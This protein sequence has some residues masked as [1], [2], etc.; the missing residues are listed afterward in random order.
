MPVTWLVRAERDLEQIFDY[1]FEQNPGAA[2]RAQQAIFNLVDRLGEFAGLG[3]SGR[4]PNTRELV[5]A[6][7]PYIVTY[8]VDRRAGLITIVRVLHGARHWPEQL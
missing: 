8:E 3:R 7:T 5:I 4:V 6:R 1:L 2:R